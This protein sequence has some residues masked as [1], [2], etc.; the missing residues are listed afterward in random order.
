MGVN[1]SLNLLEM[2]QLSF[3]VLTLNV[4]LTEPLQIGPQHT[5]TFSHLLSRQLILHL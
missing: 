3:E 1:V 4:P 2:T 5:L